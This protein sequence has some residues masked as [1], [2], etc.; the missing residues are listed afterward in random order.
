M[1]RTKG[2]YSS[3]RGEKQPGEVGE[4]GSWAGSDGVGWKTGRGWVMKGLGPHGPGF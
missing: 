3:S 4:S 2:Q 1:S